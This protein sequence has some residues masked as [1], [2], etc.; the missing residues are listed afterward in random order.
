MGALGRLPPL[1]LTCKPL[2]V[3]SQGCKLI[4]QPLLGMF[5]ELYATHVACLHGWPHMLPP[6]LT[7]STCRQQANPSIRTAP[8]RQ[9]CFVRKHL[10]SLAGFGTSLQ[11]LRTCGVLLVLTCPRL[12]ARHGHGRAAWHT[13]LCRRGYPESGVSLLGLL[14]WSAILQLFPPRTLA[15]R[16]RGCAV[17]LRPVVALLLDRNWIPHF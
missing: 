16:R 4:Q 15:K 17:G 7:S 12:R 8:S 3:L 13:R 2:N 5:R 9:R 6:G 14:L 11:M 10:G 1:L